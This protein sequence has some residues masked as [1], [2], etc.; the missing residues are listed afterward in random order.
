MREKR[1]LLKSKLHIQSE[2][3]SLNLKMCVLL[4]PRVNLFH[5]ELKDSQYIC[6]G[7]RTVEFL[8]QHCNAYKA[9]FYIGT[10]QKLTLFYVIIG[11]DYENYEESVFYLA[12]FFVTD[13]LQATSL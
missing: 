12:I 10:Y 7:I 9:S 6:I 4:M 13:S 3:C 11:S 5:P 8:I 1:K 2:N